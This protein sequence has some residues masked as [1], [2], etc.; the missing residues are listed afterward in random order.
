MESNKNRQPGRDRPIPPGSSEAAGE[1][2]RH[3]HLCTS[4]NSCVG[5]RSPHLQGRATEEGDPMTSDRVFVGIDVSKD[6]LDV[7]LRPSAERWAVANDDAGIA[8]LVDR[9]CAR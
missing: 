6:R 1:L 4:P 3:V 5:H 7:A 8:T 9:A 2:G